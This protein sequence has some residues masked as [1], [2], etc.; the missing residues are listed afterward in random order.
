MDMAAIRTESIRRKGG[1]EVTVDFML[2]TSVGHFPIE[3]TI[4]AGDSMGNIEKMAVRELETMLSESLEAVRQ[5]H[6]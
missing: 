5:K 2:H 6:A 1:S 3:L 4:S